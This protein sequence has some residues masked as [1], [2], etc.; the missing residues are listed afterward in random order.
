M[1][2]I[3]SRWSKVV[4]SC[5]PKRVNSQLHS[6]KELYPGSPWTFQISLCSDVSAY[7]WIRTKSP[8]WWRQGRLQQMIQRPSVSWSLSPA[9]S[10]ECKR[11]EEKRVQFQYS[12]FKPTPP[13][14]L[15]P[16]LLVCSWQRCVASS[17]F[18][19]ICGHLV[20]YLVLR[21]LTLL[22]DHTASLRR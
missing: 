22:Q 4:T 7:L 21:S 5:Q 20:H 14:P 8:G 10:T 13:I 6:N 1:L 16:V 9:V 3:F 17:T 19:S 12:A 15:N 11:S 2:A 18:T